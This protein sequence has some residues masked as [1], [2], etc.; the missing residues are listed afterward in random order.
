LLFFAKKLQLLQFFPQ[1]NNVAIIV[2]KKQLFAIFCA[3]N[4]DFRQ[5]RTDGNAR[6]F[7][8][9]RKQQ[10]FAHFDIFFS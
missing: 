10:F 1:K 6:D 9:L 8:Y 4:C 3:K 5:F 7:C 2:Q